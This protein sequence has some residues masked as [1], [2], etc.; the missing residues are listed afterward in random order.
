MKNYTEEN[1]L[2]GVI[3]HVLCKFKVFHGF[4]WIEVFLCLWVQK[5]GKNFLIFTSIRYW[6]QLSPFFKLPPALSV[7][8]PSENKN[9]NKKSERKEQI[10]SNEF[11][12]LGNNIIFKFT[13]SNKIIRWEPRKKL[14]KSVWEWSNR[15]QSAGNVSD[16]HFWTKCKEFSFCRLFDY[17]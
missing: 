9:K 4:R 1:P 7:L 14:E 6:K 13:K 17:S 10:Y 3:L 2:S 5:N 11:G 8:S 15:L 12:K 16:F